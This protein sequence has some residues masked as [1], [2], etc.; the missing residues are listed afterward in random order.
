[1]NPIFIIDNTGKQNV[2]GFATL[3][4]KEIERLKKSITEDKPVVILDSLGSKVTEPS[5]VADVP[6][7]EINID[8]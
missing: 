5:I 3:R 4:R 2:A 1:M 6:Y 7:V 8:R